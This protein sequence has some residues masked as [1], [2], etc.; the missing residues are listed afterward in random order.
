MFAVLIVVSFLS[1]LAGLLALM[2][3]LEP[4]DAPAVATSRATRT[5]GADVVDH[6][7]A[8]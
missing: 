2:S 4:V 8:A 1:G 7:R 5:Q 6:P 3:R